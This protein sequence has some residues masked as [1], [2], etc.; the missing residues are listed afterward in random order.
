MSLLS[1]DNMICNHNNG[2][3]NCYYVQALTDLSIKQW[4]KKG[5][6]GCQVTCSWMPL[7]MTV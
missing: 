7:T 2:Q 4:K 6:S 5:D 3:Y 1:R